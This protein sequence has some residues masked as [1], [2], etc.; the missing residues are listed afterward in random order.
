MCFF[1][2]RTHCDVP[3]LMTMNIYFKQLCCTCLF[4]P[5]NLWKH[6]SF[7][8]SGRMGRHCSLLINCSR[9]VTTLPQ[10]FNATADL[11]VFNS[12]H[13]TFWL[14]QPD[15][16]VAVIDV[17]GFSHERVGEFSKLNGVIS[18]S[19]ESGVWVPSHQRL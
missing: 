3:D 14:R 18:G 17:P 19:Q 2:Y 12:N 1:L 11:R 16:L 9:M 6:P 7:I 4:S 8:G 10:R 15:K 13:S 5:A